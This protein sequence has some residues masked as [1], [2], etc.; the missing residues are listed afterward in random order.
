MTNFSKKH[1][2][3]LKMR[4]KPLFA[5]FF[6]KTV[7]LQD[8]IRAN[9][10]KEFPNRDKLLQELATR[11]F[12]EA[13]SA[14]WY[15]TL[16]FYFLTPPVGALAIATTV[17]IG[18]AIVELASFVGGLLFRA[19]FTL[20]ALDQDSSKANSTLEE[21]Y[22]IFL[23]QSLIFGLH[24]SLPLAM[25]GV[26][27]VYGVDTGSILALSLPQA[28]L[29][30]AAVVLVFAVVTTVY[31]CY[32]F[33][34]I[35]KEATKANGSKEISFL[36]YFKLWLFSTLF[37]EN[38]LNNT[39][40]PACTVSLE[41][42][43][44][45]TKHLSDASNPNAESISSNS[46]SFQERNSFQEKPSPYSPKTKPKSEWAAR[47]LLAE[48]LTKNTSGQP[49]VNDH[50]QA[51]EDK[52]EAKNAEKQQ[53]EDEEPNSPPAEVSDESEGE[54]P[55]DADE[56]P[57]SAVVETLP[58]VRSKRN[59]PVLK[60]SAEP[61]IVD[62]RF[63]P[64]LVAVENGVF[65]AVFLS[66]SLPP[67]SLGMQFSLPYFMSL[68]AHLEAANQTHSSPAKRS[69]LVL[70]EEDAPVE[71]FPSEEHA[72][73][74]SFAVHLAEAKNTPPAPAS[75]VL[76]S[77]APSSEYQESQPSLSLK[78]VEKFKPERRG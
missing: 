26:A 55:L 37:G 25:V 57:S 49:T 27:A 35:S 56:V 47:D 64:M 63:Q 20:K 3:D 53:K 40:D 65:I 31:F 60:N 54:G 46:F 22:F 67:P 42:P 1:I 61:A 74:S 43:Q 51:E 62:Y 12:W 41:D 75:S 6:R 34:K 66:S 32:T 13:I 16:V 2:G 71:S 78:Q 72:E 70:M 39:Q 24:L 8:I 48:R 28:L 76:L 18:I 15:L 30:T 7:L 11:L 21:P 9:D 4:L 59:H 17:L 19:I 14:A 33:W 68:Y 36:Y 10:R 44:K 77:P 23:K 52:Q 38:N 50:S 5:L 73:T 29:V 45:N 69:H 58:L